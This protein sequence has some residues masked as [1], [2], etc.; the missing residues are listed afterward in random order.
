MASASMGGVLPR[1][2]VQS[3]REGTRKVLVVRRSAPRRTTEDGRVGPS[4]GS[5][6]SSAN[7]RRGRTAYL[8]AAYRSAT[9]SQATTFH[10]ALRY[11]GRR[12]R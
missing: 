8:A 5:C 10:H 4:S 1:A 11:S 2:L 6:W 3:K 7:V 12:L 9:L